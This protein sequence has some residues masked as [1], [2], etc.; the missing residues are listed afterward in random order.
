MSAPTLSAEQAFQAMIRFLDAYHQRAHKRCD[1]ASVLSNIQIIA[2]D[3]RPA[4]VAAWADW[5]DAIEAVQSAAESA[6]SP[7][8]RRTVPS[9]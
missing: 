2:S 4:D 6:P 3:A 7:P 9:R 1:L 5:L 8:R